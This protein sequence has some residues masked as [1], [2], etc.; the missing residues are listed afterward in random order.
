MTTSGNSHKILSQKFRVKIGLKFGSKFHKKNIFFLI[1]PKLVQKI[2]YNFSKISV[3][4]SDK[5]Y[6]ISSPKKFHRAS[7]HICI[8]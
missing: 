5:K 3:I 7:L 4:F 2:L 8:N 6:I 1:C